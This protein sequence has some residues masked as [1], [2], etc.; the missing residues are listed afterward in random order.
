[1]NVQSADLSADVIVSA[2]SVPSRARWRPLRAL[3][4]ALLPSTLLLA[5]CGSGGSS[6]TNAQAKTVNVFEADAALAAEIVEKDHV[7]TE[8]KCPTPIDLRKGYSFTCV[9]KFKVGTDKIAVTETNNSGDV[10]IKPEAPLVV[11]NL[12]KVE[13]EI[14][15]SVAKG[16]SIRAHVT[17]PQQVMQRSGI[18]FTC[19]ATINGKAHKFTV[20]E[21]SASGQ[22]QLAEG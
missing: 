19:T 1:M 2:A 4:A 7:D 20:T 6:A 16:T 10:S 13:H 14:E 5:A 22:V 3:A 12:G 8:I 21:T 17:C 15:Q 11:L 18:V 9:A